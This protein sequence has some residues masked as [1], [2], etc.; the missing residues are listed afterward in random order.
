MLITMNNGGFV[1]LV[2]S[3]PALH[4]DNAIVQ[5]ARVSY[6]GPGTTA[7]RSDKGLIRYLMRHHHTTPFEMVEFK[8][9][10]RMPIFVARQHFRHRTASV[11]ELSARYSEVP[12]EFFVP[13]QYRVQSNT[14]KQSSEGPLDLGP[15]LVNS[16][17][18]SSDHAFDVYRNL[19]EAGCTREL[20][21]CHLPQSTFTEFYWK[22]NL[23]NLLHY[24][25]LRMAPGAQQEIREYA[26]AIFDVVK[27]LVPI[28]MEAF[29]DFRVNAVTLT[30]PE[31]E[32]LKNG[33]KIESPGEDREFREKL[34]IL[35][36][37]SV[38]ATLQSASVTLQSASVTLQSASATL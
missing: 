24:L 14:N 4:L 35:G 37:S 12:S 1:R 8:F 32:A 21:R 20:A 31:I 13:D 9:H 17:R 16:Q 22:I 3:M 27:M 29:I 5:A 10:I 2:D 36:M 6:S 23:H 18:E 33:T 7:I 25:H 34:R 28:T 19:L 26:Q 30:G 15:G 11:N 38:S